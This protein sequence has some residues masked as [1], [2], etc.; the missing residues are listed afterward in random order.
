VKLGWLVWWFRWQ[1]THSYKLRP[2][3]IR[4]G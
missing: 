1:L 2:A 3:P 4:P